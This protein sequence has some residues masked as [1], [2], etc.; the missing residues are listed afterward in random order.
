MPPPCLQAGRRA[1]AQHRPRSVTPGIQLCISTL[2][3]GRLQHACHLNQNIEMLTLFEM[4]FILVTPL[5]QMSADDSMHSHS[6]PLLHPPPTQTS[7]RT[8]RTTSR[9]AQQQQQEAEEHLQHLG[10]F[11]RSPSS[12]RHCSC[13]RSLAPQPSTN[14]LQRCGRLCLMWCVD[15]MTGQ[16]THP[17]PSQ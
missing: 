3:H 2:M 8:P 7:V 1:P 15:A 6:Q 11:V 14:T 10:S 16:S 4:V 17:L 13:S 9:T 12:H 5:P